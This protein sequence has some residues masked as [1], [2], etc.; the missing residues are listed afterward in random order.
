MNPLL[1]IFQFVL[2]ADTASRVVFVP[3]NTRV[4]F[5]CGRE[6]HLLGV[7]AFKAAQP[8]G[9]I[10][11]VPQLSGDLLMLGIEKL[12]QFLPDS[13]LLRFPPSH[14]FDRSRFDRRSDLRP[15]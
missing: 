13:F 5:D 7:R 3:S 11:D 1:W 12:H 2:G 10:S 14:F 15:V 9:V 4:G 8:P 6:F